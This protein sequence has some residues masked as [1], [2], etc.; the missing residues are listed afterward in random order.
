M[1]K[2][3][4]SLLT[5]VIM[6]CGITPVYAEEAAEVV[7]SSIFDGIEAT[8]A[9]E[10]G[11]VYIQGSSLAGSNSSAYAVFEN[12]DFGTTGLETFMVNM[13]TQ[14]GFEGGTVRFHLDNKDTA[15]F[16]ELVASNTGSFT[17]YKWQEATLID[18]N[19]S[20]VNTVYVTYSKSGT[21]NL[22][23]FKAT[24]KQASSSQIMVSQAVID[25]GIE[26]EYSVLVALDMLDYNPDVPFDPNTEVIAK[27]F[28]K[29]ALMMTGEQGEHA[30]PNLVSVCDLEENEKINAEKACEMN[31]KL[32]NRQMLVLEGTS[33]YE[34][35]RELDIKCATAADYP[36]NWTNAIKLLYASTEVAPVEIKSVYN[37]EEGLRASYTARENNTLLLERRNIRKATGVVTMDSI[38]GIKDINDIGEDRVLIDDYIFD[39]GE[40]S[41]DGLLGYEV[42]FYFESGDFE[43]TLIYVRKTDRNN[44]LNFDS[45]QIEGYSNG[46]LEYTEGKVTKTVKIPSSASIIY[47]GIA[48]SKYDAS[49]FTI[50]DG[51]IELISNN[52]DDVV[53]VVKIWQTEDYLF[54]GNLNDT[55]HFKNTDLSIPLNAPNV[56]Y[57]LMSAEGLEMNMARLGENSVCTISKATTM[58]DTTIIYNIW[59]NT[60]T[61]N[62]IVKGIDK[63]N[64]TISIDGK[65]YNTSGK[66]AD[67]GSAGVAVGMELKFYLNKYKQ[68]AFTESNVVS[69]KVGYLVKSYKDEVD[70]DVVYVKIFGEDGLTSTY[71]CY[72]KIKIDGEI[73]SDINGYLT[74][75]NDIC[76]FSTNARGEINKLNFAINN[77]TEIAKPR[78][79]RNE[80]NGLY[81]YL[82]TGSSGLVYRPEANTMGGKIILAEGFKTFMIPSDLSEYEKSY[83]R[84]TDFS[85]TYIKNLKCYNTKL[86]ALDATIGVIIFETTAQNI[87]ISNES[88][89]RYIADIRE[90]WNGSESEFIIDYY[91]NSGSLQTVHVSDNVPVVKTVLN[92]S[93][94][95]EVVIP[96]TDL[97]VGDAVRMGTE[98]GEVSK[99]SRLYSYNAPSVLVNDTSA[100]FDATSRILYGNV[101]KKRDKIIKLSGIDD[102]LN[103]AEA[104]IYVYENGKVTVGSLQDVVSSEYIAGGAEVY[105]YMRAGRVISMMIVK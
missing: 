102:V 63:T 39:L 67:T 78:A 83:I 29:A 82:D 41:V 30:I 54:A 96:T 21:G 55:L 47:N 50:N 37:T 88:E 15:P 3:I 10:L 32:L 42:E 58:D 69:N 98:N 99:I 31:I 79:E 59:V 105:A 61:V 73:K 22:A 34:A 80:G 53:D 75:K 36:L 6:L 100:A 40:C 26:Y 64:R 101:E 7:T 4:I 46:T 16:A 25:A 86:D 91:G 87:S 23:G 18:A 17:T 66:F 93:A 65:D 28:A 8:S 56:R 95:E 51:N 70:E 84:T 92:G 72:E 60:K 20:G 1:K 103:I 45:T 62:G 44:V 57:N 13:G 104:K 35:C 77:A 81:Y 71:K 89:V 85:Y 14:S 24:P 19:I 5:S 49:M 43:D 11:G 2:R 38:T 90:E 74:G 68:V 9:T 94:K 48:V 27:D 76:V 33:Y 12:I 97:K 52:R